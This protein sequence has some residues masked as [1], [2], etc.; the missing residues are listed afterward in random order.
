MYSLKRDLKFNS[1]K[2]H[3]S[4]IVKNKSLFKKHAICCFS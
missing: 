4:K 3:G 2:M 1:Q